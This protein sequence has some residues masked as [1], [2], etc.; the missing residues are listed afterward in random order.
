MPLHAWLSGGCLLPSPPSLPLPSFGQRLG[1]LPRTISPHHCPCKI[2]CLEDSGDGGGVIPSCGRLV[3]IRGP[4]RVN[5]KKMIRGS[6]GG[7]WFERALGQRLNMA[8][9]AFFCRVLS[10]EEGRRLAL[11]QVCVPDIRWID[12]RALERLGFRGVVFD[13]DNTLTSPYSL[14]LWPPI[15]ASLGHCMQAFPGRVAIYSNSA[16]LSQYDP[17]SSKAKALED[18]IEG[19]HVIRHVT[20]KPAGTVDEIEQYFGCSASQLIMVGDRCFTDVVYGNRNG[21][22]TILTEPLNLSEEPLVVQLVRKLEQHLLTCWR[23]KGLKPLEH[24]LLS[25]WKQCT[26]SQPF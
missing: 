4:R 25:D 23:K 11:P 7:R 20:K 6:S 18:S 1:L 8:G 14:F 26:R 13:K 17:D 16:G 19:V 10:A 3:G 21:F 5:R 22:L 2:R 15:T 9:L 12:W 24:S